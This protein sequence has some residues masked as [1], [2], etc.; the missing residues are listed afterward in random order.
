MQF[1]ACQS[2]LISAERNHSSEVATLKKELADAQHRLAAANNNNANNSAAVQTLRQ[3]ASDY[4]AEADRAQAQLSEL[5]EQLNNQQTKLTQSEA[6]KKLLL[7]SIN[8]LLDTNKG[9]QAKLE[10]LQQVRFPQQLLAFLSNTLEQ[11]PHCS[12]ICCL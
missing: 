11:Q 2:K 5:Q 3:Q 10:E 7:E 12:L 6:E 4:K 1:K 9:L 8:K